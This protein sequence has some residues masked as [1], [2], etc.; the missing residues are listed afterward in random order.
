MDEKMGG[1]SY[2]HGLGICTANSFLAIGSLV[3]RLTCLNYVNMT[4]V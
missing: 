3:Q 4:L 1:H 2:C